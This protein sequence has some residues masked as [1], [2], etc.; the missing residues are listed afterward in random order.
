MSDMS[1]LSLGADEFATL[2]REFLRAHKPT[3]DAVSGFA[4]RV[5]RLGYE[6]G[7]QAGEAKVARQFTVLLG[8]RRCTCRGKA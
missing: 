8:A 4:G 2:A 6:Q 5:F 1:D 7:M 3:Q